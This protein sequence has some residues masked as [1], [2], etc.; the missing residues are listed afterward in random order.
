[1]YETHF[2]AETDAVAVAA[3]WHMAAYWIEKAGECGQQHLFR[4]KTLGYFLLMTWPSRNVH[5][6]V[7]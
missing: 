6:G 3:P 7:G 1:M 5:V 4:Q 2:L